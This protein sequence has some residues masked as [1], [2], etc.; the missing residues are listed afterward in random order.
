MCICVIVGMSTTDEK[1][2]VEIDTEQGIVKWRPIDA[3]EWL[4]ENIHR[5]KAIS[6][7]VFDAATDTWTYTIEFK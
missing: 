4:E 1:L 5:I 6:K 7:P 3:A 2:K